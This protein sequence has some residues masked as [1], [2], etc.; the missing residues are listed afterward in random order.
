M[1]YSGNHAARY[2]RSVFDRVLTSTAT[3]ITLKSTDANILL[4]TPGGSATVTTSGSFPAGYIIELRN[5]HASNAVVFTRASNYSVAGGTLTRFV[6]T[7][8]H[9]TTPVFSVLSDDSIET[10]QLAD[11]AVTL[12]KLDGIPRGKI[13]VGDASGDPSHLAAGSNGKLLVADANGD[14]S[15]TTVSGDVTISA[16]AVTIGN[17]KIDSQH[18]ADGSIDTAHIG[19]D[20]VTYAK[21]QNVSATDR[22]LG[23]DSAGAGIIEEIS[24]ANVR[25]MLN[26]ADGATAN[27]GTVTSI[28]VSGSDGIEIDSG[29]PI[30]T[31][32]TIALGVN[33]TNML[34][35]LN[36]E[37]GAD[38]T[39][40]TN[41][42]AAGAV[43]E[44]DVDAKGD[45]FVATADNTVTRL[46]VG[47]NNHVLTAD[48]SEASGVKWAAASGGSVRTVTAGGNTLGSGE[49]LA[50]TEGSN[51][52][53]SESGGAV[54][55][56]GAAL[57]G[58]WELRTDKTDFDEST[59]NTHDAD[60]SDSAYART[61]NLTG[62]S[63]GTFTATASTAGTYM[64]RVQYQFGTGSSSSLDEVS[65]VK[66]TLQLL[67][68]KNGSAEANIVG[69]GRVQI[70]GFWA[71]S[72]FYSAYIVTLAD[73]DE[74]VNKHKLVGH[75]GS[76]GTHYNIKRGGTNNL[77][78]TLVEMV[79]I[80]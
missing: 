67:A 23:R 63:S 69:F 55:I 66:Y 10:V 14:P 76:S 4:L 79:R 8:S 35:H 48:S 30:T 25:T 9:A 33:K 20:Q 61:G 7:T 57:Y 77:P 60:D 68:Y 28:A 47:T 36:V 13:I 72:H 24:P 21:I 56:A 53:I 22:L 17:D 11:N 38:V 6:C 19:D 26:V 75:T 74:L 15:W 3:S 46:A 5:L 32:G 59:A 34:S 52:A 44:S 40:A 62:F 80:A 51:I 41:V 58:V 1:Y 64:V 42:N 37:D 70:N 65:G 2:T 45:I 43:M 31:S 12:A 39:D 27:A 54:T 73:G 50:F 29:S 18:Y 71:D 78:T 49:T 16:G